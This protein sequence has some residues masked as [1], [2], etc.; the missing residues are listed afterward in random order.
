MAVLLEISTS[1]GQ[2]AGLL[3]EPP[4]LRL[5]VLV[6][7]LLRNIDARDTGPVLLADSMPRETAPGRAA[8]LLG[9]CAFA[10]RVSQVVLS[11][12][13]ARKVFSFSSSPLRVLPGLL[14]DR[15][16]KPADARPGGNCLPKNHF[17]LVTAVCRAYYVCI[18]S[19]QVA[20]LIRVSTLSLAAR[21]PHG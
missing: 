12:S 14:A 20:H 11:V 18:R 17:N 15:T 4:F 10:C 7:P 1:Q 13:D 6:D 19:P 2:Q 9:F 3:L 21:C 8:L 16:T 5:C